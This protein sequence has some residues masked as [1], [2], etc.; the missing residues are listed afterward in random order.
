MPSMLNN[1]N[2]VPSF[3]GN[4]GFKRPGIIVETTKAIAN[5]MIILSYANCTTP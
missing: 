3:C 4:I 1:V 5:V 2:P